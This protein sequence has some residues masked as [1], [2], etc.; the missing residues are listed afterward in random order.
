VY[1][2]VVRSSRRVWLAA[3]L[4]LLAQAPAARAEGGALPHDKALHFGVSFALG[5]GGYALSSPWLVPR[6]QRAAV[7]GIAVVGA[8]AAKEGYDALGYG[9]PSA[10]DFA[11][12]LA[13]GAVG[14]GVAL[15]VDCLVRGVRPHPRS[16][17]VAR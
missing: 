16:A 1:S 8:G 9:D 15:A 6:W 12:D 10:A 7:G 5:G 4:G 13:G 17:A 2:R 14:I 3:L 11:W